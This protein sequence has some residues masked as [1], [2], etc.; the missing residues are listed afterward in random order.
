ME[1]FSITTSAGE[2]RQDVLVIPDDCNDKSVFHLVKGGAEY[3]K[4]LY[5]DNQ[6]WELMGNTAI[7]PAELQEL[8]KKIEEHYF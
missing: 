8:T 6:R 1:S 4:L 5:T 2:V 7:A 3:C